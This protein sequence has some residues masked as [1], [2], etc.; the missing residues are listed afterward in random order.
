[1][2]QKKGTAHNPQNRIRFPYSFWGAGQF[3]SRMTRT[4]P[5][6][7][8]NHGLVPERRWPLNRS[9]TRGV[10]PCGALVD[11]IGYREEALTH[12]ARRPARPSAFGRFLP[13]ARPL[14]TQEAV[15]VPLNLLRLER[16]DPG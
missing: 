7:L 1:L 3:H 15:A 8:G 10:C 13:V 4:S 2:A 14:R 12:A 5:A 16:R 6:E 11:R 9:I